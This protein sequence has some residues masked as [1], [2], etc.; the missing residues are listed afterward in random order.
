MKNLRIFK[1]KGKTLCL[2]WLML[3]TAPLAVSAQQT[4]TVYDGTQQSQ[5]VPFYYSYFYYY[6]KTQHVIPAAALSDM[7][8]DIIQGIKYYATS[9]NQTSECAIDFY[10]K[11]VDNTTIS[12][13]VN[14]STATIVYTGTVS[15]GSDGTVT[16][17][18]NTP[19]TYNGGNLLI[20]VENQTKASD[21][22]SNSFYG[23][24]VSGA[25]I[26]ATNYSSP[27][28]YSYSTYSANFIPKSTFIYSINPTCPKPKNLT[29]T[30][31]TTNSATLQWTPKGDETAWFVQYK[32]TYS[33]QWIDKGTV[34]STSC[35]LDNLEE[36]TEYQFRVKPDCTEGADWTHPVTFRTLWTM[37]TVDEG[38]PYST[39]FEGDACDWYFINGTQTNAWAW[40]TATQNGGS[41][42]LYVSNDGGA[43]NQYSLTSISRSFA[44]KPVHI[45]TGN[46]FVSFDWKN[47]GE[48]NSD[49][50]RVAL[51]PAD[52]TLTPGTFPCSNFYNT[53]PTGWI[54]LDGGLRY[55]G[56]STWQSQSL[57]F[58]VSQTGDYVVVLAWMNNNNSGTQPPAAIDNFEFSY[59]TCPRPTTPTLVWTDDNQ[60]N[61]DWTP[62]GS[63]STWNM[64]YKLA[65]ANSWTDVNETINAHPYTLTGLE[66]NME[67]QVRV[68]SGCGSNWSGAMTFTTLCAPDDA[69]PFR[70]N[71]NSIGISQ[72]IPDCW[73]NSDGTT[74][75][76]DYKWTKNEEGHTGKCLMF[77]SAANS[78][79]KT[80]FLKTPIMNMPAGE[81]MQ[82]GFWYKNTGA[83]DFSVYI[84]TDKGK[85]YTTPL[86]TAIPV[87]TDWKEMEIPIPAAYI[88]MNGVVL[89]FKGTSNAS[90]SYLYLDDV[91]VETMPT[92]P[93]PKDVH[94]TATT[95]NSA[96]LAWTN[97]GDEN[98]WEI[99]YSTDPDFDPYDP[100]T[101]VTA[102]MN[103][104]VLTGLNGGEKYYAYVRAKCGNTDASKWSSTACCFI[105]T[106]EVTVNNG[107]ATNQYVPLNRYKL[108]N[109]GNK[110]QFIIPAA[111]L[112]DI[113]NSQ[114]C[115]LTFYSSTS[116]FDF[117]VAKFN[118]YLTESEQTS[119]SSNS[120]YS[121]DDMTLVYSGSLECKDNKMEVVF[122]TP[123]N[124]LGGNLMVGF[125]ETTSASSNLSN[126]DWY[127]I[128]TSS[129]TSIYYY[130]STGRVYFLPKTMIGYAPINKPLNLSASNISSASATLNWT[131]KGNET[132]WDVFYTE[133]PDYVPT[134]NTHG[135]FTNIDT[136]PFVLTGLEAGHLYYVYVRTNEGAN[137][138]SDW[139]DPC[140]F[141]LADQLTV[142]DGTVTNAQVPVMGYGVDKGFDGHFIIPAEDL[143]E[144]AYSEIKQLM[145]YNSATNTANIDWGDVRYTLYMFETEVTETTNGT[146]PHANNSI[147]CYTG[148]IRVVDHCMTL[149]LDESYTYK[150]G[151][152]CVSFH[153]S[154]SG[155]VNTAYAYWLGVT[156]QNTDGY[157]SSY[158]YYSPNGYVQS[159]LPKVTFKYVPSDCNEPTD[160]QANSITTSSVTLS[161]TNSGSG[162]PA[163]EMQYR[164]VEETNFTV[165]QGTIT[166][167]FMLQG[168]DASHGYVVR[169]R[170]ICGNDTYSEW[171]ETQFSTAD[172]PVTSCAEPTGLMLTATTTTTA[173]LQWTAGGTETTWHV[174]YKPANGEWPDTYQTIDQNPCTLVGLTQGSEYQVRVRAVCSDTET[175]D[176]TEPVNFVTIYTAPFFEEFC[177]YLD[178]YGT[179]RDILPGW[180][181]AD[182]MLDAVLA[183]T[184]P[185]E[186]NANNAHWYIHPANNYTADNGMI[187]HWNGDFYCENMNIIHHWMVSPNIE[188]SEGWK[189]S[190]DL[191]MSPLS[192]ATTETDDDRFAVLIT[193][194]NGASWVKLREWNN[195][196]GSTYIYNDIPSYP[197]EV[198]IDLSAYSNKT[199]RFAFYAES[200]VANEG[201]T[202]S[203]NDIHIGNINVTKCIKPELIVASEITTTSAK[204]NW[205]GHGET[206][207]TLQYRI[208]GNGE[209]TT[210]SNIT[211]Q[212][213]IL[214]GLQSHNYQVRVKA[215]TASGESEWSN[216]AIFA[217]E[218]APISLGLGETYEEHFDGQLFPACWQRTGSS[219]WLMEGYYESENG[220]LVW[221]GYM[222][223]RYEKDK[224]ASLVM[225][226]IEVTSGMSLTFRHATSFSTGYQIKVQI[227]NNSAFISNSSMGYV[228]D[229]LWDT[230]VDDY[231]SDETTLPLH[232]YAG[233]TVYVRFYYS[234]TNSISPTY[235]N[236]FWIDDVKLSNVNT[237]FKQTDLGYWNET[238]NWSAGVLPQ[239][240]ETVTITGKARIPSGYI[241]QVDEIHLT[242]DG[243]LIIE[244]GAQL[245]HNN[246]GVEAKIRKAITPYTITQSIGD[247]KT[248]GWYLIA[249]PM[250]NDI[251]PSGSIIS[252]IFD[253]Y[254]FNQSANLEWENYQQHFYLSP[255]FKLIN[256]KGYLYANNNGGSN[257]AMTIEIEGQLQP[258]NEGLS[259][260]LDYDVTASLAGWNLV[261]NPFAHNVTTYTTTNV[262]DGCFRM[263][264]A[265]DDLMVSEISTTDPLQPMEGFFVKATGMDATITFNA[266]GGAKSGGEEGSIFVEVSEN[267]KT[268][269]R[270]IVKGSDRK[271]LEKLSLNDCRIKI[272]AMCD[273]QEMAIV[274]CEGN[275]QS[276]CFKAANNGTYTI[277]VNVDN[278][279]LAY[280][281]LI[282]NMTGADV[283]LLENPSYTF[284]AKTTDY[285]SRF[286]LVFSA[287][288]ASTGSDSDETFAFINNGNI[289]I[290]G[291][292]EGTTLQVIDM[293]GRVIVLG[294]AKHC[295]STT[296]MASGVYVLRLIKGDDVKIQKMVIR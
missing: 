109:T 71:F 288:D 40:G 257:E 190:F 204:L 219:S 153:L 112:A 120:F 78:N 218:C 100:G 279:D 212:P 73:D 227:S 59:V 132:H 41:K 231:S 19:Y 206:S 49:Y 166:N 105:P 138:V 87:T 295:V 192:Y 258:W 269:D 243:S 217:P 143:Q 20:G 124:Y 25:S 46:H 214:Q 271:P 128:S 276:V 184:V 111:T 281:H 28:F 158:Y 140:S 157:G 21:Y 272:Y 174:Q 106:D 30:N 253:L 296:G 135:Q 122:D 65:N 172:S 246:Q 88:G 162:D 24:T 222:Y 107:T 238:A 293:M 79:G 170:T 259:L 129:Y 15:F 262:A 85:T 167:P 117:G 53:L 36:Y 91:I 94:V 60:A 280:L 52:A 267:G 150:G 35:N 188:L 250:Q 202:L 55:A 263:N 215:H 160:L 210:V 211:A 221:I 102:T 29:A 159:F 7:D 134:A 62:L 155:I 232:D 163:W 161:W 76:D 285:A 275:E 264:A 144:M 197:T 67:Y 220:N 173:T 32:K 81:T 14:K 141:M 283:D 37:I 17:M 149:V 294:D 278:M 233:Q 213:Y 251:E 99:A 265:H 189:F 252:N 92:C 133:N 83:G 131:P 176:W 9:L 61:L 126:V 68:Q 136:N 277:N 34:T 123:Y 56:S 10:L 119:Y 266:Q 103:P 3:L 195:A 69:F 178:I 66:P 90:A 23:Q 27:T 118:V 148:S 96:T 11:E 115:K 130:S 75:V 187:Y 16:I 50:L 98:T 287:N 74:T 249:S 254:R 154:P 228:T 216:I 291:D 282:D 225:P 289:V 194:D 230:N 51:A 239:D 205:T 6:T 95:Q 47:E 42:S 226:Q 44:I 84:S 270:L 165:V 137:G 274:P 127:G 284:T 182:A 245:K 268:L 242:N 273:L 110:S 104:F 113:S 116:N 22:C 292:V 93:K 151:N 70:E 260:N 237:F 224:Y 45:G 181:W 80:N 241:A 8:G 43:T 39:G 236:P 146:V 164:K 179:W 63:E 255:Y 156:T 208:D 201:N 101:K 64:Q 199:V 54:A 185:L 1:E 89:V 139:S 234:C 4:L 171:L 31:I 77:N 152:L 196:D 207:W 2:F 209:W 200:T 168:L 223:A 125:R 121:M 177:D 235:I 18:F 244:D 97:G 256:G 86:A 26:Y 142:N 229:D 248:D 145:F 240:G 38:N 108:T 261:G 286:R 183:G 247:Q 191:A 114:I 290:T 72:K 58:E 175:S 12:S 57:E 147:L 13:F 48:G 203:S 193:E 33:D 82:L 5:F 198:N 186:L 180:Q 169:V